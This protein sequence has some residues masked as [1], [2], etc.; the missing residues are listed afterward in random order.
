MLADDLCVKLTEEYDSIEKAQERA[1]RR[2]S[3]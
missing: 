3:R 1:K 2:K